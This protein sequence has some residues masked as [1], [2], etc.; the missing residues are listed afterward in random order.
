MID[1]VWKI[2]VS[3]VAFCRYGAY[4]VK[5]YRV[6]DLLRL[7]S[8]VQTDKGV[9][10]HNYIRVYEYFLGSKR[11]EELT[12]CEVG[13][14]RD[15]FQ[16]SSKEDRNREGGSKESY[17][18]APSL[19]MWRK[20][21][22]KATIIGFDISTFK[23]P[24]GDKSFIVQGDQGSREDL[25][26]ILDIKEEL[27]VVIE[28]ALHASPH[29]QITLSYLFPHLSSGG[30]FFIEDLHYQPE[31]FEQEGV[32]KTLEL[33]RVLKRT[34]VWGSPLATPEEKNILETQVKEIHFFD[35]LKA[36]PVR[37]ADA[38]AVI[39]KK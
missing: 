3:P 35:S 28:D 16:V 34:G 5:E 4:C 20:Y 14:L 7:A 25:K 26:K 27:D 21:L 32:P 8:S 30:M 9:D 29:Q 15:R 13:L 18:T 2:V 12:F 10:Q 24:E 33:L 17:P 39:V 11:S 37:D 22:P 38:V 6:N 1:L 23:K 19:T 36:N 31:G